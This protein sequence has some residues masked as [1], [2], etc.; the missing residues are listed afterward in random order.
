MERTRGKVVENKV[1]EFA[2]VDR[3]GSC[4]SQ[5]VAFTLSEGENIWVF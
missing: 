3:M 2:R 1:R 4:K 5:N